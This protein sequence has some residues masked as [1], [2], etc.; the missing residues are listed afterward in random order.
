MIIEYNSLFGRERAITIPYS[1]NFNRFDAHFS[2][3][4]FGTSLKALDILAERKGYYFAGSNSAGI[5]AYFV[6]KDKRGSIPQIS[7]AD[8]YVESSFRQN[9]NNRGDLEYI[10]NQNAVN[11]IRGLRVYDIQLERYENF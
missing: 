1:E 7:I 3:L 8:G 11:K 10:S 5:N 4:Y 6:R 2:G 9:R